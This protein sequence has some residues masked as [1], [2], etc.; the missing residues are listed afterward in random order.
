MQTFDVFCP[1]CGTIRTVSPAIREWPRCCGDEMAR[2]EAESKSPAM[3]RI[4]Q[5]PV[6][7]V[8]TA[9]LIRESLIAAYT[10][11]ASH[12]Y[13]E[14]QSGEERLVYPKRSAPSPEYWCNPH[15]AFNLD[16]PLPPL[17][18]AEVEQIVA[19]FKEADK[20]RQPL[21]VSVP[22]VEGKNLYPAPMVQP[23]W[24]TLS[25]ND[26]VP[27]PPNSAY[28]HGGFRWNCKLGGGTVINPRPSDS[29]KP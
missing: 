11:F 2:K 24:V 25:A 15:D 3:L 4:V 27:F 8:D 7:Q 29:A 12:P 10:D 1:T 26:L 23:L 19:E 18:D 14:I 16:E 5:G 6:H 22:K 13:L 20:G 28:P 9:D 21:T 17:T